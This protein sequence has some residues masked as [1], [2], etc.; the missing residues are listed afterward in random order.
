MNDLFDI[1]CNDNI[2]IKY[3]RQ[4]YVTIF[5]LKNSCADDP[6]TIHLLDR[7]GIPYERL[8]TKNSNLSGFIKPFLIGQAWGDTDFSSYDLIICHADHENDL[9]EYYNEKYQV[10]EY[11]RP[12]FYSFFNPNNRLQPSLFE[13]A[14]SLFRQGGWFYA[15]ST[16]LKQVQI[17]KKE[18]NQSYSGLNKNEQENL[19]NDVLTK[20]KATNSATAG[21]DFRNVL[22]LDDHKREFYIGDSCLWLI[23]IRKIILNLSGNPTVT[24]NCSNTGKYTKLNN[25]LY[26]S[27]G[28]GV[29]FQNCLW[30]NI[31]FEEYDLII[32]HSDLILKFLNYIKNNNIRA[33][34]TSIYNFSLRY[35]FSLNDDPYCWN[36]FL[37]HQANVLS[38]RKA[39]S[40]KQIYISK[41]EIEDADAW[42]EVQG[43][44]KGWHLIVIMAEASSDTKTIS[45]Q[46]L[47]QLI[48]WFVSFN[49]IKVLVFSAQG[50]ELM[51]H[52]ERL[53]PNELKNV[54]IA[55]KADIRKS[56]GILA[57]SYTK[58]IL[59]P[60]T[61]ML[62]LADGLFYY[63]KNNGLIEKSQ[64]PLM[65]VYTGKQDAGYHP[66]EWWINSNVKCVVVCNGDEGKKV[67]KKLGR[68]PMDKE[69]YYQMALSAKE[70]S[71]KM[72]ID[73]LNQN[74]PYFIE[75]I[76][77]K[78]TMPENS[79]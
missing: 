70:I 36:Y 4:L 42:L 15:D 30:K 53:Q 66:V 35:E 78:D 44:N 46:T 67:L 24:I 64:M 43:M 73:Y 74:L 52:I 65:M 13:K 76:L 54:I 21:I 68:C 77:L 39:N 3:I 31:K 32:C 27:F 20:I 79:L 58:A 60:C 34:N 6:V 37:H 50:S 63:L 17:F 28:D 40:Y 33:K 71:S 19:F 18:I 29:C 8:W 59:G 16:L 61:G 69:S 7:S 11:K 75:K 9:Y 56:M 23:Y 22:I 51:Y 45:Y 55:P 26:G 1:V 10:N 12:L 2:D 62:H 57:S 5:L 41:Q 48:R 49:K 38:N 14:D 72:I 25:M 47:L